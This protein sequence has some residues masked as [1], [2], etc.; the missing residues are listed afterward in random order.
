MVSRDGSTPPVF[1]DANGFSD[2]KRGPRS[3]AFDGYHHHGE[4]TLRKFSEKIYSCDEKDFHQ[5]HDLII[6]KQSNKFTPLSNQSSF[7]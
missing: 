7:G 4:N 3:P 1:V 5:I 2:V 6:K